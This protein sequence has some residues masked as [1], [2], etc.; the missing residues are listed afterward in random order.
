MENTKKVHWKTLAQM[1][2][3]PRLKPIEKVLMMDIILYA[4]VKGEAFPSHQ[5]LANNQGYKPRHI[6]S[7]LSSLKKHGWLKGWKRRGYGKSNVY[8]P[9]EALYYRN[10]E[11]DRHY[12]T[13]QRGISQ[14][15]DKGTTRPTNVTNLNSSNSERV[16]DKD[17]H[18]IKREFRVI[19]PDQF[20]PSNS[21]ELAAKEVWERLESNKPQAF[22]STYLTAARKGL[23]EGLFYQFASE[24]EQDP[25]IKNSGA[26]FNKK[27]EDYLAQK[28]RK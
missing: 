4:G 18:T 22:M 2:R 8:Y 16:A 25:N 15:N 5:T 9:N 6:R 14:P 28:S 17:L 20:E 10:D 21:I 7:C 19:Y 27:V 11:S 23:P 1:I 3:N 24:I 26:V 13:A 12:G